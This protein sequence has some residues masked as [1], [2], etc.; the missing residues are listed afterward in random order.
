M[1]PIATRSRAVEFRAAGAITYDLFE[2]RLRREKAVDV[3]LATDMI[4]LS[5]IY[6]VAVIV[7]G[8]Q[9]YVPAVQ[10]VKDF[11]K[12]VMNVAFETRAGKLLPGGARRLNTV[13]DS[14]CLVRHMDLTKYLNI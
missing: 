5:D 14:V 12:T 13:T 8:D 3:K 10:A 6:D 11:G 7:S 1:S 4:V 2:D 9:D